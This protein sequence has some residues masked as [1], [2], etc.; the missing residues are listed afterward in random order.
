MEKEGHIL[1]QTSRSLVSLG[2]ERSLVEFGK[3]GLISKAKQSLAI[4][5]QAYRNGQAGFLDLIDIQR[6][7]LQFQLMQEKS[8][9]DIHKNVA[10]IEALTASDLTQKSLR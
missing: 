3:A 6:Q 1:I 4:T 10:L 5:H 2:T 9:S 8:L 7:L